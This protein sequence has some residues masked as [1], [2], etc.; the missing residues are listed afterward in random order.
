[1]QLF[2]SE[3]ALNVIYLFQIKG[4]IN[5]C[6]RDRQKIQTDIAFTSL[7]IPVV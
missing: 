5:Y 7:N 6:N 4:T 2:S 1:M 3:T